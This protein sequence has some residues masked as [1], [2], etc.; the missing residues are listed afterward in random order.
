M[1]STPIQPL[2]FT[3]ASLASVGRMNQADHEV[4]ISK[5][6]NDDFDFFEYLHQ[7]FAGDGTNALCPP[8]SNLGFLMD[9]HT[10]LSPLTMPCTEIAAMPA[11]KTVGACPSEKEPES[12]CT[13]PQHCSVKSHVVKAAAGKSKPIGVSQ[14]RRYVISTRNLN[15]AESPFDFFKTMMTGQG[16]TFATIK[17]VKVGYTV[18]PS[19]LQLASFGTRLVEAV[20]T[21]DV[22]RLSS[23][24][25]CGLSPNP[26][27]AFLDLP[28]GWVCRKAQDN[29]FQCFLDHHADI[30]VCDSFGR[31]PLHHSAWA[32]TFSP[33]ITASIVKVD[34]I[35]LL[36][37]DNTGRT[38]LEYVPSSLAL[39]WIAFLGH[40]KDE[41]F[42][43]QGPVL[44]ATMRENVHLPDP[45]NAV[46]ADLARMVSS[47]ELQPEQVMELDEATRKTWTEQ[48]I[49]L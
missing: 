46:S 24:F 7:L 31:T 19:P 10:W 21:S 45:P 12:R 16:Y 23:F 35:Q 20:H 5:T 38:P 6:D 44:T 32:E 41:F 48:R 11:Q 13:L 29:V 18:A 28:L 47:G 8:N 15:K 37:E 43:K 4:R 30:R 39:E 40:H 49:R 33:F 34:P 25:S 17:S 3:S 36:L 42:P 9:P 26:C 22:K 1:S 14:Y 2:L 27:N